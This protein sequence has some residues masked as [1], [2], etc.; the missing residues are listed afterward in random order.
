MCSSDLDHAADPSGPS[1]AGLHGPAGV[2]LHS[3]RLA[4]LL[5][6]SARYLRREAGIPDRLRELVILATARELDSQFEWAAHEQ[7]ARQIGI[8]PKVIEV[9]RHGA[10]V[11]GLAEAD[12]VTIL[13]CREVLGARRLSSAT[14]ARAHELLGTRLLVDLVALLGSYASTAALLCAFDVQLHP[15]WAPG[16]PDGADPARDPAVD[17][18]A[19]DPDPR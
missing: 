13:L 12:Q 15:G 19:R 5:S 17:G 1:Y 11:D 18:P 6:P 7:P 3:P 9:V 14:Y 8:E 10:P 4:V 16:L 2:R